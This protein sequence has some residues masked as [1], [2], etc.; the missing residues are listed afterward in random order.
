VIDI[1]IPEKGLPEPDLNPSAVIIGGIA[2]IC[3]LFFAFPR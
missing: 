2:V 1:A 3:G